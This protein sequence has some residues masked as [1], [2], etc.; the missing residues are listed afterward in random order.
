[1]SRPKPSA[2][3][4]ARRVLHTG[5]AGT[6]GL[7][8]LEL[9]TGERFE[10]QLLRHPGASAI[11]PFLDEDRVLLLRQYRFAIDDVLWE[12]PAGKLEPG[13][14]PEAC[15][16]RELAEETGYRAGR[17]ERTGEIVTTPGFSDERIWLFRAHDLAPGPTAHDRELIEVHEVP[18][19]EALEMVDDGRITDA[20]TI[21]ALWHVRPA[22][23]RR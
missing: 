13:E 18:L 22:S 17:L 3:E 20:K 11:V 23:L 8:D 15:A 7:H 2:T 21:A 19:T 14:S 10:L 4:H 1:M 12:V 5:A 9:S 16:A 6:F